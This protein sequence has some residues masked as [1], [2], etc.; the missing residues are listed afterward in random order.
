MNLMDSVAKFDTLSMD[1]GAVLVLDKIDA[2]FIAIAVKRLVLDIKNPQYRATISRPVGSAADA[3]VQKLAGA[4]GSPGASGAHGGVR[5]RIGQPGGPG[6]PGT[7]GLPAATR[8][9]PPIFFYI[10]EMVFGTGA[11][12]SKQFLMLNFAGF[13]GGRGG[14]GGTGGDGGNGGNGEA[15]ASGPFGCNEGGGFGGN[16]GAAGPG[17]HGGD[18]GAAGNGATV[19]MFAPDTNLLDFSTTNIEAGM[20]G[21]GGQGGTRGEPGKKG[22]GARANGFCEGRSDGRPGAVPN[23]PNFGNGDDGAPGRRGLLIPKN[24]NNLDLFE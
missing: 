9:L 3:I 20:P 21:P 11:T 8:Q 22:K 24:R 16:G 14:T 2:P 17:G 19:Y 10:Q 13:Q 4:P 5:D 23:P 7:D 15:G 18:G 6:T 12:P 1:D